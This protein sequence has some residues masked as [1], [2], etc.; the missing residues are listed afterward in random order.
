MSFNTLTLTGANTY[1]GATTIQAGTLNINSNNNQGAFGATLVLDGGI[2]Q[3]GAAVTSSR[4]VEIT[5]NNGIIDTYGFNSTFSGVVSGA[6]SLIKVNPGLLVLTGTNT[7]AGGT[8]IKLGTLAIVNDN[9]LGASGT[10]LTLDLGTLQTNAGITSV[11]NILIT[12][13][14]GAINTNGFNSTLSGVV[15]GTGSLTKTGQGLLILSGNNTYSGGTSIDNGVLGISNDSNLGAAGTTLTINGATLRTNAGLTLSHNVDL[16]INGGIIDT[17]GFHSTL[18]G[19]LSGTGVFQKQGSGILTLTHA[20]TLGGGV[21][22]SQGTLEAGDALALGTG[23]VAVAGGTL[24]V[25]G[26]PLTLQIASDYT[27]ASNGTLRLGLGGT[28]GASSDAVSVGGGAALAG[29]LF[30]TTYTGFTSPGAGQTITL[31]SAVTVGG[32]FS[33][34]WESLSGNRFFLQYQ[35]TAVELV[36]IIPTFELAGSTANQL[37]V[38]RD[39]E[40]IYTKPELFGLAS[41]LGVLS[42]SSL[43]TIYSQISPADL[44]G[45]YQAGFEGAAIKASMLGQRLARLRMGTPGSENPNHFTSNQTSPGFI[46]EVPERTAPLAAPA[47]ESNPWGEFVNGNGGFCNIAGDGNASGYKINSFGL[48]GAGMDR[49]L[50]KEFALGLFVGYSHTEVKPEDGGILT[51]NGGQLGLYGT[52][53]SGGG[54]YANAIVHGG[55]DSYNTQRLTYGGT[56]TGTITGGQYSGTLELGYEW[57]RPSLSWGPYAGVQY[58]QVNLDA[59]SEQ[60]SLAPLDFPPQNQNSLSSRV[61]LRLG[62]QMKVAVY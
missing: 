11:R 40:E 55:L 9:N 44:A 50:S 53:L 18:S 43:K 26:E 22:V 58:T 54:L 8:S 6:G 35:P 15:A 27:Q 23:S 60:G 31:L 5:L 16:T 32:Q 20:N 14:N 52:W 56:A 37:A 3:T 29:D 30:L 1:S 61:G 38:G 2:L 21:L 12:D 39:L 28:S 45:L 57:A 25:S 59:F 36:A 10:T 24:S 62:G 13:N 51:G 47:Q 4:N 17:N 19:E 33:D 48:L 42:D 34:R 41:T 7:Y 49:W 46:V